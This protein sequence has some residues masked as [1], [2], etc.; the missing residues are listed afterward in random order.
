VTGEPL[1][2]VSNL[3]IHS[4]IGGKSRTIVSGIDLALARGETIGIVGESGSG[5]SMTARA[6]IGL[7]P[8]GVFAEGHV[9]YEG[10]DLLELPE[11]ALRKLRG[12]ELGL[13]F[14]DPF[15]M[16]NPI[17]R[18]GR[19]IDEQLRDE[20][21]RRLGRAERRNE[22]VRRLAEVGIRDAGV[23]ERYPFELSGGMRQRVGIAAALARDPKILIADEPS[24][25]LD[26]TTQRE[27][28]ALIKSVQVSRGMGLIMITHDLRVAFAMCDR[29]YVLY[30]GSLLEVAPAAA[31]EEEPL[32]PYTLGLLLSEP[33]GDRRLAHL[34]S[35]EGAVPA[36][37]DVAGRCPFSARCSWTADECLAGPTPLRSL[38][39]GRATACVRIDKIRPEMRVERLEASQRAHVEAVSGASSALV[40]VADLRKTFITGQRQV[41]ALAGVSIE[42][43]EGESVGLVG[44]SGSGKT[45]LGRCIVGLETPTSGT[46]TIDGIE[47]ADYTQLSTRDRAAVR[48]SVQIVFQDPYSSLNPVRTIGSALQQAVLVAEPG[49]RGVSG[50]VADL[51]RTVGLPPEYAARKPVA[52]S[53]GE[54]QRVAIARALAVKPRLLICDEPVSA[55]DVSVQAQILNLFATLRHEFGMSYLF[56]THDLAVVRQIV[57][58]VYVLYRGAVVEAGP[59][60]TVL[61]R[62]SHEYTQKLVDSIPRSDS[63][64]LTA[65]QAVMG[66]APD[67]D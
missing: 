59:V 9:E 26:V 33:P 13:V 51:L 40:H 46:I 12:S 39:E 24:T 49:A 67:G 8:A 6:L 41:D 20:R 65:Q 54:R 47:A 7:L 63:E 66:V 17:L 55:L 14:Q 4:R 58:R 44:E 37:D 42:V 2:T 38:A 25:A 3:R 34:H 35:I 61:G 30:A 11:R 5:K 32:H 15:T 45:T 16:L 28:L 57:E 62:P 56:I 50:Q 53:G 43:G 18:C 19:H 1:L 22:A 52:L 23:A 60:D 31:V 36:P 29:I 64:W 10:R 21:G 48:R 27:I